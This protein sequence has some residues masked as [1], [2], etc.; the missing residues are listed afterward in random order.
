[1][2]RALA[3]AVCLIPSVACAQQAQTGGMDH[4]TMMQHMQ[5]M[6]A[7]AAGASVPTEPGQGA[8]AAIQEIV[9]ILEADPDTDWSK[10]D[11]DALRAHLVDMN[12]VTLAADVKSEPV[13]GGTRFLV[14][15]SGAVRDSVRRMVKAHAA[16]MNEVDGW[17]FEASD[18]EDGA[19]LT[20]WPPA[21]DAA[22]LR[23]L[24][25]FGLM[26]QGMHHQ[27]HHLMIARG[28]NPHL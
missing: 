25:F 11:I 23:G 6:G 20:V 17:R 21:K 22:K 16:A 19:S 9:A 2:I 14:T 5:M 12:A 24:G 28:E 18:I 3:L 1:M 4:K 15:G 26:A 13:A 8:F 27:Q 7:Q 10:V